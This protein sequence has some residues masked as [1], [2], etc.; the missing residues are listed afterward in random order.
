MASILPEDPLAGE[1]KG[2]SCRR[3]TQLKWTDGRG[4]WWRGWLGG[5][6]SQHDRA[7]LGFRDPP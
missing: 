3:T 1:I 6:G 4:I 5:G 2:W 7:G